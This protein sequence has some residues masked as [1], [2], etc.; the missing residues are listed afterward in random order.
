MDTPLDD[1]FEG[2]WR[3]AND[4]D[5]EGWNYLHFSKGNRIVQ[6]YNINGGKF[7]KGQCLVRKVSEDTIH[8]TP[9]D[10]G[11]GWTRNFS[12]DET[13]NLTI[14]EGKDTFPCSRIPELPTWLSDAIEESE[15]FFDENEESWGS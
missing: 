4:T 1:R 7:D 9:R 2:I 13:G 11:E 6:F 8:F 3:F 10:G 14:I 12:F 5:E 15:K